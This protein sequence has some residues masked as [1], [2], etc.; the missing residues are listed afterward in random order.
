MCAV[1][2]RIKNILISRLH[3]GSLINSKCQ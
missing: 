1:K 2:Y 3:L